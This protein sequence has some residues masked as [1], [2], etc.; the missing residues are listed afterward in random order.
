MPEDQAI[1]PTR[2]GTFTQHRVGH[3]GTAGKVRL[4]EEL[5]IFCEKCGYLLHGSPQV[6]C[7]HCDIL[8]FH[9]PECG[10]HQP[11]NTLRPAAQRILGRLRAYGLG[12]VVFFKIN[13]FLWL[14]FAWVAMGHEW[15]YTYDYRAL[16]R[17]TVSG[18]G[19]YSAPTVAQMTLNLEN[20]LAFS[21]FAVPFAMVSRMLL[22]RWQRGWLI[23]LVLG[24]AVCIMVVLGALWRQ[25]EREIP[26]GPFG[27][28]FVCI[29]ALTM[30]CCMAGGGLIWP[31][32]CGLVHLFLP[33]GTAAAL[34][35]WQRSL[36]TGKAEAL[37]RE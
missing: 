32:W 34:L 31:L 23:G 36:A 33:K 14:L 26:F 20:I 28:D 22:L 30:A 18:G 8:Q 10:H 29:L 3:A 16:Q 25:W 19:S 11:I 1:A 7:Q 37:V 12:F 4:G 24:A 6:R 17:V 9:C 15:S 13:F 35:D 21:L 27:H 5:P 2:A